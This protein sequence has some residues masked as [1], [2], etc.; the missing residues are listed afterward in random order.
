[1]FIFYFWRCL[2]RNIFKNRTQTK[3]NWLFNFFNLLLGNP[4]VSLCVVVGTLFLCSWWGRQQ[5]VSGCHV[6][7]YLASCQ[8]AVIGR[9]PVT[10]R[11]APLWFTG[12]ASQ[13]QKL[14][15]LRA[16]ALNI[17]TQQSEERV[18]QRRSFIATCKKTLSENNMSQKGSLYVPMIL[19]RFQSHHVLNTE[20][21]SGLTGHSWLFATEQQK[22][23]SFLAVLLSFYISLKDKHLPYTALKMKVQKSR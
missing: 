7:N 19:W 13:S 17:K 4:A 14:L 1:M 2:T 11:N 20:K 10:C 3:S 5:L 21:W 23:I 16:A 18:C 12:N 6:P 15:P 8:R 22:T 9:A